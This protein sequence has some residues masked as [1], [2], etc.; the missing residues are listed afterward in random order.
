VAAC[1]MMTMLVGHIYMGTIGTRGALKAMKTGWVDEA[2]AKEHHQ[3]WYDDVKAGKL[4]AQRSGPPT[5][6]SVGGAATQA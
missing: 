4:P 2:W 1:L 5:A 3:L 6:G